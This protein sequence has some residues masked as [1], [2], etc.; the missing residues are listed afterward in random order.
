MA[1]FEPDDVLPHAFK[2]EFTCTICK[3]ICFIP[4]SLDCGP[5]FFCSDC[6]LRWLN[7]KKSCPLCRKPANDIEALT[8]F[9]HYT[10]ESLQVVCEN[11]PQGCEV[12]TSPSEMS[13]H[14]NQCDFR[15]EMCG[16][17]CGFTAQ[18]RSMPSHTLMCPMGPNHRL[19]AL[20]CF[21]CRW[22]HSSNPHAPLTHCSYRHLV[23]QTPRKEN[24]DTDE[25]DQEEDQPGPSGANAGKRT[26][27]NERK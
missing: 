16:N 20:L 4:V 24:G 19:L 27:K 26:W 5:H 6:I 14:R 7:E 17:G 8:V 2:P 21:K 18:R 13:I 15:R 3:M 1:G 22:L 9:E 23:Q 25:E 12:V 11:V 10:Y